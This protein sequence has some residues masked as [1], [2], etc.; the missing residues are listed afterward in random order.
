MTR[1]LALLM[2][3]GLSACAPSLQNLV[4]HRH[5]RE[6]ICATEG[7]A[8]QTDVALAIGDDADLHYHLHRV[9]EAELRHVLPNAAPAVLG[10]GDLVRL[11][12]VSQGLPIDGYALSARLE[13][14][15]GAGE[16]DLASWAT[17]AKLT[18]ERLPQS[19]IEQTY[20]TPMNLLLGAGTILTLGV[21]LLFTGGSYFKPGYISR[22]PGWNDYNRVAPLTTKLHDAIGFNG[23]TPRQAAE[24]GHVRAKCDAY[25]VVTD[26]EAGQW[27]LR[28]GQIFFA[29]R[30]GVD[31]SA[32]DEE[33]VCSL[34]RE[35]V[36][37]WLG[38]DQGSAMRPLPPV[39]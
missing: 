5:Y 6:A 11:R 10:R 13:D 15:R 39:K 2:L 8:A 35:D 17:L 37:P 9:T 7:Q 26:L 4:S 34:S 24:G 19:H 18:G 30:I 14:R 38:V 31:G 32:R 23:C 29:D 21:P 1:C 22:A 33:K 12:V 36:V 28:I 20:A 25:F 27:Q 3:L 16:A